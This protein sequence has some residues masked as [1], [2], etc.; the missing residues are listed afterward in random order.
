MSFLETDSCQKALI[1]AEQ[2]NFYEANSGNT[3][4]SRI[5]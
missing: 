1:P 3:Q 4:F 5:N 2:D